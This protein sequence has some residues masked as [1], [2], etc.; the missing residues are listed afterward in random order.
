MA[1]FDRRFEERELVVLE[2]P[3]VRGND[4][5][6]KW[7]ANYRSEGIPPLALEGEELER[8]RRSRTI[9]AFLDRQEAVGAVRRGYTKNKAAGAV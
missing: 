2:G 1:N 6:M 9:H 7:C 4:V 3:E 5:W 8:Q